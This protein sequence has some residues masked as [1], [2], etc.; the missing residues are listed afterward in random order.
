M[1]RETHRHDPFIIATARV[2]INLGTL[3]GIAMVVATILWY[4][5]LTYAV[6]KIKEKILAG[7][8][9]RAAELRYK[10]K[11]AI[12]RLLKKYPW[13]HQFLK[14]CKR[15]EEL[16]WPYAPILIIR[17]PATAV[18]VRRPSPEDWTLPLTPQQQPTQQQIQRPMIMQPTQQPVAQQP[19]PPPQ[20]AQQRQ[21]EEET[22][23]D[24]LR[25]LLES[26]SEED[27][28][29]ANRVMELIDGLSD[30]DTHRLFHIIVEEKGLGTIPRY[31]IA[32]MMG[33]PWTTFKRY[34]RGDLPRGSRIKSLKDSLKYS[35]CK[36]LADNTGVF[37]RIL[38]RLAEEAPQASRT[39]SQILYI[40]RREE[41][42][43]TE[44]ETNQTT[45]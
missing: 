30:D 4:T 13:L 32:R 40:V 35:L 27:R 20:Q 34:I 21:P 25:E 7:R 28:D 39:I 31:R 43:E 9:Y 37:V 45:N 10:A 5:P 38:E 24:R 22:I 44:Q 14:E 33:I 15:A 42:E 2:W 29:I 41:P 16:G 8:I 23:E 19:T 3:R 18:E 26:L 17:D 12:P 1:V 6:Q 11:Y 36:E